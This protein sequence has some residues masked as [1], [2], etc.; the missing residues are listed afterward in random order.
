MQSTSEPTT[1][2]AFICSTTDFPAFSL[3]R[4]VLNSWQ[5]FVKTLILHFYANQTSS[6]RF[7]CSISYIYNL[8][9]EDTVHCI[10]HQDRLGILSV[11]HILGGE[12]VNLLTDS[13]QPIATTA[14]SP[15]FLF[16]YLRQFEI[17]C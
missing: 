6:H 12:C 2:T 4:C 5:T 16:F 17:L 15:G 13:S 14:G 1:T 3:I 8:Y 10:F 11:S 7:L 9:Y